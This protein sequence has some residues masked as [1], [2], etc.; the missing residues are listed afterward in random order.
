M[1]NRKSTI[2][3]HQ[4][5][6]VFARKTKWTPT[7]DLAFSDGPPLYDLPRLPVWISCTFTW[8][9]GRAVDLYNLWK[10]RFHNVKI[11]KWNYD[12]RARDLDWR[13]F[14]WRAITLCEHYGVPYY[15]KEDLAKYLSGIA[16]TSTDTRRVKRD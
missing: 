15:V 13:D 4:V 16:Y 3:N 7:D 12:R 8:D 11:G 10:A 2:E 1:N 5:I 6:R 14:G 9:V